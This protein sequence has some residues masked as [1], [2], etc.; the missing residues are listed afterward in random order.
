MRTDDARAGP[1]R[2][3]F[4]RIDEKRGIWPLIHVR[5]VLCLVLLA[6]ACVVPVDVPQ[7]VSDAGERTE[8]GGC[9]ACDAG[10]SEPCGPGN[11]TGCC[12]SNGA[13]VEGTL[14]SACGRDGGM[15]STCP[16]LCV[17]GQCETCSAAN[18]NG[19]CR[20]GRCEPGGTTASCGSNGSACRSCVPG[21]RCENGGCI[22]WD[23]CFA[24]ICPDGCCHPQPQFCR[25][26]TARTCGVAGDPC[27]ACQEPEVCVSGVCRSADGGS[28]RFSDCVLTCAGCCDRTG[29]CLAGTTT[30]ACGN[31]GSLCRSCARCSPQSDGGGR[32]P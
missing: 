9:E 11:C 21:Q 14:L 16:V 5:S 7:P 1:L 15:C 27:V 26:P 6:C 4:S 20:N 28:D 8:D 17:A 3:A 10:S 2:W 19:C 24:Q 22:H 12:D 31:A 25:Q 29:A 13:C 32:C 23:G 30:S 18:C